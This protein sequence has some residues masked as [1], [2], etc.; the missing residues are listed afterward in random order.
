MLPVIQIGP[1]AV[2]LPGLVIL[3]GVWFATLVIDRQ[4]RARGENDGSLGNLIFL[5]LVAGVLGARL[6]FAARNLNLYVESPL[7][8]LSLQ[9]VALDPAAGGLAGLVAALVYGRRRGLSLWPS[10][11]GLTPGLAVV[12][13]AIAVAHVAS[14]DA[15]GAASDVPWAIELWGA[16]RHPSQFYELLAALGG[17]ALALRFANVSLFA[18]FLFLAWMSWTAAWV[19]VLEAF[20]GDSVLVFGSLRSAQLVSLAALGGALLGMHFRAKRTSC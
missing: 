14:G 13:V 7:G 18:G 19:L 10:L 6:G 12:A 11:D 8:L 1:L 15:F 2:Q 20:R 3:A 9:P 5:G 16:R 17:L 4:A